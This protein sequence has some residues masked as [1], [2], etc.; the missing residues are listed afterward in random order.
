MLNVARLYGLLHHLN[1]LPISNNYHSLCHCTQWKQYSNYLY[2]S[3]NHWKYFAN[4]YR[5]LSVFGFGS[6]WLYLKK[7]I[8][9]RIE[10]FEMIF[11]YFSI[12]Q[13]GEFYKYFIKFYNMISMYAYIMVTMAYYSNYSNWFF[14]SAG[15]YSVLLVKYV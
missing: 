14:F 6:P 7:S 4:T 8:T 15:S 10:K 1:S 3:N 2:T 9:F 13:I 11:F 12:Q 5:L